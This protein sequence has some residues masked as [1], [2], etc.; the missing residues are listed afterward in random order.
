MPTARRA[1]ETMV[2][3]I[4]L[5]NFFANHW[6]KKSLLA[7]GEAKRFSGLYD[8]KAW[9]EGKHV[10]KLFAAS[11]AGDGRQ[12]ERP[13]GPSEIDSQ[14]AAGN[15]ICAEVS[16]GPKLAAFLADFT[17]QL[18]IAGGQSFAKLYAS[19]HQ[20]GFTLHFDQFHVFVLQVEGRKRW[21]FES[22]PAVPHSVS[23]GSLDP[24]GAP[25]FAVPMSE[26]PVTAEGLNPV[27]IPDISTFEE[28]VLHEGD[29][30][31]LPPGTWHVA[32]AVGHS[33][34]VSVSPPR[35]PLAQLLLRTLEDQLLLQSQWRADVLAPLDGQP[36][37]GKTFDTIEHTFEQAISSLKV[38]LDA[39]DRRVLH[40][41]FHLNFRPAVSVLE[42]ST[43]PVTLK[44]KL[45]HRAGAHLSYLLA[46]NQSL[47]SQVLVYAQGAEF[48]LP[49]EAAVFVE[50]LMATLQFEVR[51][52]VSWDARLSVDE[53]VDLLQQLVDAGLLETAD[54]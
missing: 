54:W 36:A 37:P 6:G 16:R 25:V 26:M 3:P 38:A 18:R 5:V 10:E 40:R 22:A 20:G 9:R 47:Q 48:S 27:S 50:K 52:A 33:V 53:S 46:P 24:A 39:V 15:T 30:L 28:A 42:K 2:D 13:I 45:K 7:K 32:E 29:M 17:S 44:T 4:S 11:R 49:V 23:A 31:Y 43:A 8:S 51:A 35:L 21:R 1:L 34:A 14:L 12:V 41:A 19:N